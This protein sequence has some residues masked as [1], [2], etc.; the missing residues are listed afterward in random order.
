[1]D[2]VFTVRNIDPGDTVDFGLRY[3]RKRGQR[4]EDSGVVFLSSKKPLRITLNTEDGRSRGRLLV[5]E[6]IHSNLST[7]QET[8]FLLRMNK[9]VGGFPMWEVE[10]QKRQKNCC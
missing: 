2:P 3:Q 10:F 6:Q 5:V 4:D 8:G 1:M 7:I 9:S